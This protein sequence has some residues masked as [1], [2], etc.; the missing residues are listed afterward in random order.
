MPNYNDAPQVID[1][2]I[3][4]LYKRTKPS[5]AI[6]RVNP[7]NGQSFE[8]W[9]DTL[10]S[11]VKE[12]L[13]NFPEPAPLNPQLCSVEDF[14]DFTR[15]KYLIQT[16]E[17]C[18][19]PLYLLTPK[20]SEKKLPAILCCHGHGPYGKDPVAGVH[21][22]QP[23]R[24]NGIK[25]ANY[26]YGEIMAKRGYITIVPDW[27]GFGE[28]CGYDSNIFPGRDKCNI[29]FIQ[30]LLLGRTLLGA[31]IFDGM[32]AIDFLL[33]KKNVN[34]EKIGCM[35]LSQG[36]TMTTYITL[37]DDRIKA[38]DII[39]YATTV[40]HY[41]INRPNFCGSQLVPG[42]YQ[43][44]D[45][46]DVIGAI[47]PRPLLVESGANDTCFWLH[48]ALE[49]HEKI[50]KAYKASGKDENLWIE[51]FPGEHSFAAGKAFEFFDRHLKS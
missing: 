46:G 10:K 6:D 7:V 5:M 28:R 43:Y 12:L 26:N 13:G 23:E 47:A 32:R 17:D 1:N 14:P 44:A 24:I 16:E 11:K 19:M 30:H 31:N 33:T 4:K 3:Y 34:P 37:L 51:I 40:A 15:E 48:S 42:L 27:R 50:K 36:G 38:A 18:W 20:T 22:N 49:A 9:R 25:S 29:Y 39:C 21:F 2:F 41:A 35:G 45:V 8:K